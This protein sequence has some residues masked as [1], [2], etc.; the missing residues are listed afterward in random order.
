MS[1]HSLSEERLLRVEHLFRQ[2]LPDQ[3]TLFVHPDKRALA[4]FWEPH[5]PQNTIAFFTPTEWVVLLAHLASTSPAYS[6]TLLHEAQ[7]HKTVRQVLGPVR[8]VIKHLRMKLTPFSL[9]IVSFHGLGY[10]L[11][12]AS[13]RTTVEEEETNCHTNRTYTP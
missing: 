13:S 10:Q 4:L 12:T 6:R 9:A 3:A 8:D 7:Q 11:T 5:V 1:P 2:T